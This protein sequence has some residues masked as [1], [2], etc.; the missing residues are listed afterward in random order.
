MGI[1]NG[2]IG[3]HRRSEKIH[4]IQITHGKDIK[5]EFGSFI[6]S[7]MYE[8]IKFSNFGQWE[9]NDI[10]KQKIN[11]YHINALNLIVS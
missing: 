3:K 5:F 9:I 7:K 1:I 2:L 4:I 6:P 10:Y 8:L 11:E